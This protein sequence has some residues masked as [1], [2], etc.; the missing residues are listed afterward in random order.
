MQMPYAENPYNN[1]QPDAADT[2]YQPS[3]PRRAGFL[4]RVFGGRNR[5]QQAVPQHDPNTLPEHAHPGDTNNRD[6]EA[7]A[8]G[9]QAPYNKYET[10]YGNN[11][12]A[13]S[14]TIAG[15]SPMVTGHTEG[16]TLGAATAPYT[17]AHVGDSYTHAGDH[18]GHAGDDYYRSNA[19]AHNANTAA[20]LPYPAENPYDV[21][22]EPH[23]HTAAVQPPPRYPAQSHRYEDGIYDRP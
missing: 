6:S 22:Y 13:M 7:T 18:Y 8:V 10:G 16:A 4:G 9:V 15:H 17:Y 19:G 20:T 23:H 5:G 2:T 14:P 21:P 1:Y 3:S 12:T 11:N